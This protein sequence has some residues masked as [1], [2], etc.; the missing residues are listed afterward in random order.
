LTNLSA[1]AII[2]EGIE[3]Y[4]GVT[5]ISIKPEA[6]RNMILSGLGRGVT[7]YKGEKGFGKKEDGNKEIDILYTVVTR[8][9]VNQLNKEIEK[10]DPNAFV[11][12]SSIK[13]TRGGMIKKRPLSH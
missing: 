11:I 8:L 2:I 10:I 3:E 9:E 6:I 1:K 13:D 5:I 4:T 7:I 12:M